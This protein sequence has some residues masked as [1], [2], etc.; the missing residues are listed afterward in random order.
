VPR[1]RLE[2]ALDDDVV[3]VVGVWDRTPTLERRHARCLIGN[4]GKVPSRTARTDRLV[5]DAAIFEIVA[6]LPMETFEARFAG[7]QRNKAEH[8]ERAS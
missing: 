5:R 6:F 4:R 1:E 3:D 7:W 8:G 2:V